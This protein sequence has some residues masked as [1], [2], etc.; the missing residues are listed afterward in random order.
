[1]T[2][3]LKRQ[4]PGTF[5]TAR[6]R[7]STTEIS[8]K[9]KESTSEIHLLL[10]RKKGAGYIRVE[11]K[12]KKEVPP[13]KN[14]HCHTPLLFNCGDFCFFLFFGQKTRAGFRVQGSGFRVYCGEPGALALRIPYNKQKWK[15]EISCFYNLLQGFKPF[16]FFNNNII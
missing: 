12:K 3:I 14:A 16:L 9:V 13:K 15:R 7:K 5:T 10:H 11:K 2:E 4:W 8:R 1:M 6:H